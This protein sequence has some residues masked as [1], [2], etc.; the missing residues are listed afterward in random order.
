MPYLNVGEIEVALEALAAAHPNV[1][2]RVALPHQTS[3]G[4][5][6]HALRIGPADS[7]GFDSAVIIGG[8]HARE[9][10]PPDALVHLAAD[11][12]DSHSEGTGLRYG[13]QHFSAQ[14]IRSLI[15][16]LQIVLFPCAN[17]DGRHHSQTVEPMWRKNRRRISASL[18]LRC[19]GVD[20]NRNFDALWDFRRHF[21]PDSGVSASADPCHPQVYI[22]PAVCSEAETQNVVALLDRYARTRWFIDVHSYVPA[23]YH[24]WGFDENQTSDPSMNFRNPQFDGKRGRVDGSYREFIPEADLRALKLLGDKMNTAVATA[25]GNEYEFGQSF[26]LYPTS[27]ASDDYAFSRHFVDGTKSKIFSFTVECGSSFQPSWQEAEDVIRELCAGL[28][29]FSLGAL[30]QSREWRMRSMVA[31]SST[32][33][34]PSAHK[35]DRHKKEGT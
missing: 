1:T 5:Q 14:D 18:D 20:L 24:A 3:E 33:V 12:L 35:S 16:G 25:S 7:E 29:A 10:V 17:P 34:E 23:I 27:G 11:L 8:L 13:A 9:W 30:Q 2:E 26:S 19:V 15:E 22:G 32:T 21:A 4:R 28:I 6:C 31:S